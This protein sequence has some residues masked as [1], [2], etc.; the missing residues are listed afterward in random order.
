MKSLAGLGIVLF[1]MG[2]ASAAPPARLASAH[3]D[4]LVLV[5]LLHLDE[6]ISRTLNEHGQQ[7]LAAGRVTESQFACMKR[8]P[9]DF[10]EGMAN[11][12]RREL[13]S[14][15]IAS[16]VDYLRSKDGSVFNEAMFDPGKTT[17][18][19]PDI[20]SSEA[21][22]FAT[23]RD[24]P[25]GK[26][27]FATSMLMTSDAVSDFLSKFAGQLKATCQLTQPLQP[28]DTSTR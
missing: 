17:T 19:P 21:A 24:S 7:A 25:V 27:L 4:S 28:P 5:Q 20:G 23:F 6:L 11:A 8:T 10:T 15:E 12:A 3:I 16:A 22:A 9:A 26:K 14:V 2:Q 13:T 18:T 1:L